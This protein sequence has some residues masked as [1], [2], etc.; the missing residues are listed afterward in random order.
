VF[1]NDQH[2][3]LYFEVYDP[4]H[5][6]E[7]EQTGKSAARILTNA[8]F[9]KGN[10][11]AFETPLV[12]ADQVNAPDRKATAVELDVPLA[13]L[14]PGFYTCQVNVIDDAAGKFVFPRLALLVR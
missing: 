13:S 4:A 12:E 6:T 5:P 10:V 8:T 3:F 9:F 14:K 11:K 2:L 7:G 1:S